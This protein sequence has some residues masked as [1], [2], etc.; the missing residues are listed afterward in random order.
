MKKE[1]LKV[2][3]GYKQL[4]YAV[5]LCNLILFKTNLILL[6]GTHRTGLY[7]PCV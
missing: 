4:H 5:M 6:R 7:C 3:F 1:K 2:Y